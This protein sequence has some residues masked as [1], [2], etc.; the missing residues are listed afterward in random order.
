MSSSPGRCGCSRAPAGEIELASASAVGRSRPI[1]IGH[2]ARPKSSRGREFELYVEVRLGG[3]LNLVAPASFI[4]DFRAESIQPLTRANAVEEQANQMSDAR[5]RATLLG[6]K[7]GRG[8][9]IHKIFEGH[10]STNGASLLRQSKQ[11]TSFFACR[12]AAGCTAMKHRSERS[13][14]ATIDIAMRDELFE[15]SAQCA[16]WIN[17]R[18]P[19]LTCLGEC[20]ESLAE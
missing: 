13:C 9:D 12:V 2:S 6:G 5:F 17:I 7:G 4:S 15:V 10:I 19:R 14:K 16:S 1:A 20:Q 11:P 8:C 3:Q 18:V